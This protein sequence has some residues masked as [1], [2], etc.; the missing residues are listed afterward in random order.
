LLEFVLGRCD[1]RSSTVT[2][3]RAPSTRYGDARRCL[4]AGIRMCCGSREKSP[5]GA[6]DQRPWASWGKQG[7][8]MEDLESFE[9]FV[10]ARANALLRY[11]FVLTGNPHD[12]E[13][14]LQEGLIRLRRA[15]P[16]VQ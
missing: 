5:R 10:H 6:A 12:A 7:G 14:L 2:R 9:D 15:W 3:H 11:G 8:G 13:D 4:E 16:R 1:A